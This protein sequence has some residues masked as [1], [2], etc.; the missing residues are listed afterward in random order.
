MI[1]RRDFLRTGALAAAGAIPGVRLA[2]AFALPS[3][4]FGLH[5]L[6]ESNPKA[7]FI[8]RT[9]V[10][11]KADQ[12]TKRQEGLTLARELF[13]PMDRPGI[14]LTHRIILKPNFTS[15]L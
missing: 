10:V 14:P 8:R 5:P 6:I 9:H 13:V 3:A 11:H 7:V 1:T 2:S 15:V 12:K 4:Y